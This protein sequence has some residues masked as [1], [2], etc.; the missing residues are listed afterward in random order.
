MHKSLTKILLV[1]VLIGVLSLPSFAQAAPK[2]QNQGWLVEDRGGQYSISKGAITLSAPVGGG[3]SLILYKPYTPTGDFTVSLKVQASTL[4]GFALMLRGSLPFAG[5]TDGVN[6]EFGARDGGS[7]TLARYANGWTWNVF[8]TGAQENT[9][10]TLKLIVD[11]EQYSITAQ[12]FSQ[13][14][15]LLGSYTASDMTNFGFSDIQYVGFGVL[16][17][18]G[19][20]LVKSVS[21]T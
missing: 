1:A 2:N 5:S 13:K 14:G 4:Q 19:S 3:Q 16:E 10:Y 12:V 21:I 15:Q 20:Y 9:W 6:F 18:G 11:S 7:F 8:T 17:S